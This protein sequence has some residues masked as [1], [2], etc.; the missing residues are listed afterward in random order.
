MKVIKL[1]L[2]LLEII[3]H[4]KKSSAMITIGSIL[5]Y[6]YSLTAVQV[7]TV[8]SGNANDIATT[9]GVATDS[10][11]N[12]VVKS[13]HH[14]IISTPVVLNKITFE[15]NSFLDYQTGGSLRLKGL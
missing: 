15:S 3:S 5:I 7:E 1:L 9:G 13:G 8:Q 14:L 10:T 2:P 6:L 4:Y 12:L 11:T